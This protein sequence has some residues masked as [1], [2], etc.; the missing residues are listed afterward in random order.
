MK[1]LKDIEKIL[2]EIKPPD[3]DMTHTRHEVW[4]RI[5]KDRERRMKRGPQRFLKPWVWALASI[6]LIILCYLF[7]LII[8]K[9]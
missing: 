3:R 7:M 6:I 2:R 4:R 8:Y 1:D 9:S 5:M